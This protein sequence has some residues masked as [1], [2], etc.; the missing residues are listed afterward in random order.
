MSAASSRA[1][2]CLVEAQIVERAVVA[3]FFLPMIIRGVRYQLRGAE[4]RFDLEGGYIEAVRSRTLCG[5]ALT[6]RLLSGFEYS[7]Q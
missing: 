7:G 6:N 2:E 5:I 4:V 3:G 1:E